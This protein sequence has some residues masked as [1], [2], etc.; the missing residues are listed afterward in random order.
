[1]TEFLDC[2]IICT[3]LDHPFLNGTEG[4]LNQEGRGLCLIRK[5]RKEKK[6]RWKLEGD[7][8]DFLHGRI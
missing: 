6:T 8:V 5:K 3:F 4:V 7:E 1:V 2:E